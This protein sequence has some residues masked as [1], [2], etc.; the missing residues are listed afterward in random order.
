M[1]YV[2]DNVNTCE[3]IGKWMIFCGKLLKFTK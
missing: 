3:N 2:K 1:L